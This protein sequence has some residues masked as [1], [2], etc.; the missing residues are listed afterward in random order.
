MIMAVR[1]AILLG[2]FLLLDWY[3]YQAV[4]TVSQS[5]TNSSKNIIRNIYWGFTIFSA[6]FMLMAIITGPLNAPKFL[7]VYV[8]SFIVLVEIA[9][10]VGVSFILIDDIIRLFRWIFSFFSTT[11]TEQGNQ[12]SRIKFL[13]QMALGIA[14]IP[15]ASL[16][17]GM[18]KG[19]FD[20]RV[21]NVKLK[22]SNLPSSFNGLKIVQL[23]DIHTG[24]FTSTEHL[25]KAIEIVLKQE[26]DVIFFTGDL[27]ND[28]AS[29]LEGFKDTLKKI[30]APLGVYSTLGNHDYGDYVQWDTIEAKQNNLNKICEA[31]KEFGWKLLNNQNHILEKNGEKIAILGVENWGANLRFPKYGKIDK[32]YAGTENIPVKLLLSHDPSHWDKQINQEYKDID[33]MFSGH[34]HGMQFGIEIPGF[35]WSPSQYFY[36]QWAGLYQK[37]NQYLYVN[38]GLGFIGYPGRVGILPE[39]TVIELLRS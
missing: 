12:I 26:P 33:V 25:E 31:H 17:Y 34:T 7:R 10:L 8:F 37:E 39:I 11:K 15:L 2:F 19:A 20:Y 23:S 35:K 18:I 3:F 21:K 16:V 4:S 24:S 1:F 5:Y 14:A 32:A 30:K 22:L 9:K 27:V 38:R 6:L 36:K 13:Q 28:R 29:E